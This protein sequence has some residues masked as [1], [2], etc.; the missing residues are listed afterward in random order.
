MPLQRAIPTARAAIVRL[1]ACC[2]PLSV[3]SG[4]DADGRERPL[5]STSPS[6]GASHAD[7]VGEPEGWP[8]KGK[9]WKRT[10]ACKLCEVQI[11]LKVCRDCTMA[12]ACADGLQ[13]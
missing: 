9:E 11:Q 13:A 12:G 1:L 3:P 6:R 7:L 8:S 4:L 5:M 10:P 2:P